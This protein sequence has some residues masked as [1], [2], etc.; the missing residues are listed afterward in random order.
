MLIDSDEGGIGIKREEYETSEGIART[1]VEEGRSG[2][3]GKGKD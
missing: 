2:G 3:G 1:G